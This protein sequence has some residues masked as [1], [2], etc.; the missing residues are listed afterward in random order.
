MEKL[1]STSVKINDLLARRWSA[2]SFDENRPVEGWKILSLCEAARWA[3]SCGGDE[4]WRFIIFD[5]NQ[6]EEDFWRAFE[7]LDVGN[8]KWVK[9][10]QVLIAVVADTKW[11]GDRQQNNKW[12]PFDAGASAM[13]IYLQAFDLGL[14]AHPMAGFD[15]E[16]LR[17][18][19]QI[20]DDYEPYAMIAVGYP[21]NPEDLESPYREREFAPRK[22]R[23]LGENFFVNQWGTP[24]NQSELIKETTNV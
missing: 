15:A 1:A 5:R 17:K 7:T 12:A 24:I 11:R 14:Y 21:G 23:P 6:S 8:Q 10:A 3:P 9:R 2:R 4:P 22:R 18:E 13:S 19:F 16:R 20:P